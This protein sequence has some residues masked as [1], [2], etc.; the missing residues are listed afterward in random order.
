MSAEPVAVP[1]PAVPA[2]AV[3]KAPAGN[4][5]SATESAYVYA[6]QQAAVASR[7][8]A[9]LPVRPAPAAPSAPPPASAPTG[10]ATTE[11]P[12]DATDRTPGRL[13]LSV[14]ASAAEIA[15]G[16]IMTV[17][18]MASSDRAVVDAPLHLTFDPNVV[19]FVDGTVGDFLAQG[20]S[21]VVFFADGRTRPGDVAVAVGRV[22]RV[23]GASGGGLL[24]RVRFRGTAAGT[25]PVLVGRAKAWG[26]NGEELVV[27]SAGTNV[28]VR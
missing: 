5:P 24:C 8:A 26:V 21:S 4:V 22:E 3:P 11:S 20:G 17:D 25:T 12:E 27:S 10:E 28:L 9:P 2:P 13:Q 23:Q 19:E 1:V 7:P 16:A 6:P 14:I 18:V 15:P